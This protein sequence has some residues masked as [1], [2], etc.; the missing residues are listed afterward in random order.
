MK[1]LIAIMLLALP[2]GAAA[3]HM[4]VI[5]VKLND[6]CAVSTYLQIARDFN[7]Q[8]GARNEY[9]AEVLVP[10]QSQNLVSL[11]WVG[12][13]KD[14]ATFGKAWDTW[15]TEI[16]DANSVAGKLWTRFVACSTNLA[17][18]GYDVYRV[19]LPVH[20]RGLP[21]P[22]GGAGNRLVAGRREQSVDHAFG[23][24][25]VAAAEQV[26][27]IQHVIEVVQATAR[28]GSLVQRPGRCIG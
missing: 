14:A 19:R 10:L 21:P 13:S 12:R 15:R 28:A 9:K 20:R 6:G 2:M 5:E 17:R 7:T 1:K 16:E 23:L 11:Y 22:V 4:D 27:V 26:Q 8:W 18:R 25:A 24:F 3:D